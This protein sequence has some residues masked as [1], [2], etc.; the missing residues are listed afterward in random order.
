MVRWVAAAILALVATAR[1]LP[2]LDEAVVEDERRP[3]EVIVTYTTTHTEIDL[4][5]RGGPTIPY[6][7]FYA[8]LTSAHPESATFWSLKS[9]IYTQGVQANTLITVSVVTDGYTIT[10]NEPPYEPTQYCW[11]LPGATQ[12]TPQWFKDSDLKTGDLSAYA[13][14]SVVSSACSSVNAAAVT[15]SKTPPSTSAAPTTASSS[16]P[17]QSSLAP[18]AN[19]ST[20]ASNPPTK[21][22]GPSSII[23]PT[24][25]TPTTMTQTQ[26]STVSDGGSA[27]STATIV[28]TII[29]SAAASTVPT[30]SGESGGGSSTSGS[31][32]AASASSSTTPAAGGGG[33]GNGAKIGI[34]V[35]VGGGALA[36]VALIGLL[37]ARSTR[38]SKRQHHEDVNPA[39]AVIGGHP[40]VPQPY[41][42]PVSELPSNYAP[43]GM[44]NNEPTAYYLAAGG[45]LMPKDDRSHNASPTGHQSWGS[46]NTAGEAG[47]GP[48]EAYGSLAG[49]GLPPM[50]EE[51]S[52]GDTLVSGHSGP[53]QELDSTMR[54]EMR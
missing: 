47:A 46:G 2:V 34:G 43:A 53:R 4:R 3:E 30:S 31:A 7:A 23:I 36:I 21:S 14:W 42:R 52:T 17:N 29:S 13:S 25:T 37:M 50:A 9:V 39:P 32:V 24:S 5:R 54:H 48:Y 19:P 26:A 11:L 44:G 51:H 38:N 1:S 8:S 33:L 49:A 27:V 40:A 6:N 22:S 18:S 35:G 15:T 41:H 10:A 12:T 20:S 16:P 28:K 45:K